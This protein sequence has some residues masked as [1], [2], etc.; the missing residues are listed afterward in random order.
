MNDH[1][2]RTRGTDA[3]DTVRGEPPRLRLVRSGAT[4]IAPRANA[5]RV[6]SRIACPSR[7]ELVGRSRGAVDTHDNNNERRPDRHE[8]TTMDR[9]ESLIYSMSRFVFGLGIGLAVT[10]AYVIV[11]SGPDLL[12]PKMA[13]A[14]V[15]RLDPIIVRIAPERFDA[16]RDEPE[17]PPP[18]KHV[19]GAGPQ[20]V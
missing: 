13:T 7:L 5:A 6:E 18:S 4:P 14:D 1:R 16:I 17:G 3:W 12:A 10:S 2:E 15:V 9:M 8:G 11:S 20:S 19:Y